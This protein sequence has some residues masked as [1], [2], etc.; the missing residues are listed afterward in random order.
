MQ[1]KCLIDTVVRYMYKHLNSECVWIR[2]ASHCLSKNATNSV[3]FK[4][5]LFRFLIINKT[6]SYLPYPQHR[7]CNIYVYV[8][9]SAQCNHHHHHLHRTTLQT[10][11]ASHKYN[12]LWEK[13]QTDFLTASL[14]KKVFQTVWPYQHVVRNTWKI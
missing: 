2:K 8:P 14:N 7:A 11:W 6:Y 9:G 12:N 4:L 5:L 13:Y 1:Q 10:F 3:S